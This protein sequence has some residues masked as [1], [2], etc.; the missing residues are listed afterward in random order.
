MKNSTF[1]TFVLLAILMVFCIALDIN[2]II[3]GINDGK[4]TTVILGVFAAGLCTVALILD[5]IAASQNY[6]G[7]DYDE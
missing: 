3:S 1:W 4:L 6:D 2:T 7:D 5:V